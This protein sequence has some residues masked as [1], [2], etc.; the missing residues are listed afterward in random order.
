M[1][2]EFLGGFECVE[3]G[4][5]EIKVN[6]LFIMKLYCLILVL[7]GKGV[8]QTFWLVGQKKELQKKEQAKARK[9]RKADSPK[10][11]GSK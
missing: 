2:L 10:S 3:R 4:G 1:L 11:N 5:I 6:Y 8:M 7:Q 9:E